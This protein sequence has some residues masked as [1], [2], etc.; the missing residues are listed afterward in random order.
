[1]SFTF[2]DLCQHLLRQG[3]RSD[4]IGVGIKNPFIFEWQIQRSGALVPLVIEAA[5]K[6]ARAGPRSDFEGTI[7]A[8]RIKNDDIV[9]PAHSFEAAWQIDFLV[10]GED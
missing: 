2:G 4:F 1:V 3:R 10:Q 8:V 7:R 9:A 6:N 5:L